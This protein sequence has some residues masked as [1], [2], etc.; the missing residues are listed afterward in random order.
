MV[1]VVVSAAAVAASGHTRCNH[2]IAAAAVASSG[3]DFSKCSKVSGTLAP[4]SDVQD[5]SLFKPV[6]MEKSTYAS[7]QKLN[8]C[9][10]FIESFCSAYIKNFIR[11]HFQNVVQ[12]SQ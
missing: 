6:I 10:V 9:E 5:I 3:S 8:D 11:I 1:F 12:V 2:R 7:E 4:R